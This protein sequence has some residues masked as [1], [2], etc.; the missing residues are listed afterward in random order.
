MFL[1]NSEQEVKQGPKAIAVI[2][3]PLPPLAS[4]A[5]VVTVTFQICATEKNQSY[6]KLR[7]TPSSGHIQTPGLLSVSER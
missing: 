2:L 5:E 6:Q 4:S 1:E 7:A 3:P